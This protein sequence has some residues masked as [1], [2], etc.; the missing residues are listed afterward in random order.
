MGPSDQTALADLISTTLRSYGAQLGEI[1]QGQTEMKEELMGLRVDVV[2]LQERTYERQISDL[3]ADVKKLGG[4][5]E[6]L[7]RAADRVE[8]MSTGAKLAWGAIASSPG[9]ASL[10]WAAMQAGGG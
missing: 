4:E 2:R 6:I 5:V 10:V 7:R 8:G 9:I 3:R 1:K